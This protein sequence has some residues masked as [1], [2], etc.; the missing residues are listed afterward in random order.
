MVRNTEETRKGRRSRRRQLRR[1]DAAGAPRAAAMPASSPVSMAL[2]MPEPVKGS[3][4]PSE[5]PA[6]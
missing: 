6:R 3:M 5:S 4:K 2:R 1:Y